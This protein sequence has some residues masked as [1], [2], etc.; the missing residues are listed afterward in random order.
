[1]NE[2]RG[3]NLLLPLSIFRIRGLAAADVTQL[4][5]VAG[6]GS[7]FFFLSLYMENVLGYSPLETGSAYLPLCFGV[8][9]AAGVSSQL[10]T[11]IGT[12]PVLVAGLLLAAGA[13]TGCRASR[14]TAPTRPTCCRGC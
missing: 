8:A 3:R 14:W 12:R 9:V 13:S 4:V 1:M 10:L 5:A 2:Q 7:M 6:I 11:R